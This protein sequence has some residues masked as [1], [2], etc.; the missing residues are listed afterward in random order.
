MDMSQAKQI[1]RSAKPPRRIVVRGDAQTRGHQYGE[2]AIDQIKYSVDAY[3]QMFEVC[4]IDWDAAKERALDFVEPIQDRFSHLFDE[5]RGV[6]RGSGVDYESLLALNCRTEILPPDYLVRVT[7]LSAEALPNNGHLTE[8]TSLAFARDNKPVWLA[9]NW[10][11]VGSQREALVML[12]SHPDDGPAHITITE[13]GMLAKIGFNE[14][15]FGVTLNILRS[16]NDGQR[17][18][19]PTHLF[20]RALLDCKDTAQGCALAESLDYPASS[21]IMVADPGGAIASIEISPSGARFV[22]SENNQLC[23]TNHY[24][25][26]DLSDNDAGLRGNLSTESR[27]QKAHEKIDGIE[28]LNGITELLS[29]TS[30]D[31]QSVCRFPDPALPQAAQVESVLGVAMDLTNRAMWV[32]G[33]QPSD[34]AFEKFTIQ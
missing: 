29:D 13:A 2:Q 26:A 23:H 19:M 6:S 4:D 11:W 1:A 14:K 22:P 10:D 3:R 30:D 7:Q 20:L 9:Q 18:G 31:Y 27:L 16:T 17:S 34:S 8:C 5:I 32:T 28:D 21:N 25:H 33:A 24:L 12:E 15:G